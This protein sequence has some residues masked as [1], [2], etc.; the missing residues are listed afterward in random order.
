MTNNTFNIGEKVCWKMRG[1]N[2]FQ[3]RILEV[4][5]THLVV[6]SLLNG[7]IMELPAINFTHC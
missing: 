1:G 3:F 7:R 4:K 6:S 2:F 5:D